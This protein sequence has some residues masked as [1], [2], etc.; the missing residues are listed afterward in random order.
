MLQYRLPQTARCRGGSVTPSRTLDARLPHSSRTNP[1]PQTAPRHC[2]TTY[3]RASP[4]LVRRRHQNATV[5]D[6]FKRAPLRPPIGD[7]ATR[8]PHPAN[9]SPVSSNRTE[10]DGRAAAT[11]DRVPKSSTTAETPPSTSTVVPTS[12]Q[13]HSARCHPAVPDVRAERDGRGH[14]SRAGGCGAPRNRRGNR[15]VPGTRRA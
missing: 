9:S 7:I 12:S 5:M 3:P 11:G 14:P 8:E 4:T 2:A 1:A 13:P 15:A 6:G 10:C